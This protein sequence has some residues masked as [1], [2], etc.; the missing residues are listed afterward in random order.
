MARAQRARLDVT[1]DPRE[2][3]Q[4][5]AVT[6]DSVRRFVRQF[7]VC[8]EAFDSRLDGHDRTARGWVER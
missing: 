4:V 8:D 2:G 1:S 7:Q 5:T 6:A 3:H